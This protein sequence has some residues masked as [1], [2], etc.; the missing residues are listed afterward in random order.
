ME[1]LDKDEQKIMELLPKGMERPRP[2]REL[3]KLTGW[4]S[5]RVRGVINRLI[6]IHHKPIGARYE[7]PFNGYY[8]I[9][10]DQERTAALAPLTSQIMEMTKRAQAISN[11]DLESED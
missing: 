2:L 4:S 1:H 7:R 5:R 11:A 9:T 6:V 10:N 8:I 3:I